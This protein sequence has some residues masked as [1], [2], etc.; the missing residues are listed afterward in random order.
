MFESSHTHKIKLNTRNCDQGLAKP[1]PV[2]SPWNSRSGLDDSHH[3]VDV[4]SWTIHQNAEAQKLHF[5]REG[6]C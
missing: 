3:R 4:W 2:V 6:S 1:S 5:I